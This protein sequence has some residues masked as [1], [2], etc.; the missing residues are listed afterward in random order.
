MRTSD[1]DILDY[2]NDKHVR[3]YFY[4]IQSF[5]EKFYPRKSCALVVGMREFEFFPSPAILKRC[6]KIKGSM[7]LRMELIESEF[8][9]L[10]DFNSEKKI[11]NIYSCNLEVQ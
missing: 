1:L 4:M 9:L 2:C 5:C 6:L 7:K 8:K 11:K 10:N 3:F